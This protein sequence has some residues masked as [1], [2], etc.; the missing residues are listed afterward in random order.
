MFDLVVSPAKD[1]AGLLRDA[2]Y[3]QPRGRRAMSP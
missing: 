2:V 3:A 1:E